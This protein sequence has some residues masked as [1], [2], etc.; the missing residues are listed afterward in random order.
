LA[1]LLFDRFARAFATFDATNVAKLFAV[2]SVALRKDGSI[3]MLSNREDVVGY[4]QAA[5]DG[6]NC[7]GCRSCRWLDL[8]VHPMG[9]RAFLAAVS[10]ELL[11]D[12]GSVALR[13]RQSY[14][15]S[16]AGNE[17]KIFVIIPLYVKGIITK[18]FASAMHVE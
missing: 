9:K 17:P 11:R 6:Y 14:G 16:N 2:P 8:E 13:W 5:L 4:Y 18:I 10:W 7:N 3:V 15:I 12:D 1:A